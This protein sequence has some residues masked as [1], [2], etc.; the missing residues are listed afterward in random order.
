MMFENS[1]KLDNF[2]ISISVVIPVKD[3]LE[4]LSQTLRSI[5]LQSVLPKEIVIVDDGSL[6]PLT[7]VIIPAAPEGI[8]VIVINNDDNMGVAK[9]VNI[10]ISAAS[11]DIIS[12]IDSDDCYLPEA[13]EKISS[14]WTNADNDIVGLA[15]GFFWCIY[16]LTPY[17][18]QIIKNEVITLDLLLRGNVLGGGS[19][20]SFRRKLILEHSGLPS[21]IASYDYASWLKMS[22]IGKIGYIQE[23]LVLYRSPSASFLPSYTK[24]HKRRIKAHVD[25]YKRQ[26]CSHRALMRPI[27]M[28]ILA[29]AYI[30]C[31]FHKKGATFL[32][33]NIFN[34]YISIKMKFHAILKLVLGANNCNALFLRMSKVRAFILGEYLL[35]AY[36][37]SVKSIDL[38]R[39]G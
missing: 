15:V 22:Q 14:F 29:M 21:V 31:G 33:A 12:I 5:Y 3:R 23:P 10:G 20:M 37:Y 36:G 27:I 2:N 17:R 25:I 32:F 18:V 8:S 11:G 26:E 6:I 1:T 34:K 16:D 13:L 35:N 9:S 30:D 24:Q 28:H 4:E 39:R 7:N 19:S 38:I